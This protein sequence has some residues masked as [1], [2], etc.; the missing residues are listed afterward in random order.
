VVAEIE[1][2]LLPAGYG[3]LP[4]LADMRAGPFQRHD[5]TDLADARSFTYTFL[6]L[7]DSVFAEYLHHAMVSELA[8]D[9]LA[10]LGPQDG[11]WHEIV[12]LPLLLDSISLLA[13]G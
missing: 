7:A 3:H 1:G 13:P 4:T 11:R 12:G 10:T 9:C 2:D 6:A 8:V 5:E